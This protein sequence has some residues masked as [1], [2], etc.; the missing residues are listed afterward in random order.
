MGAMASEITSITIVYSTVY[1]G[2]AQRKH[3]SSAPL[4]FVNSPVSGEFPAQM[5]SNAKMFPFDDVI[6]FSNLCTWHDSTHYSC[7]GMCKVCSIHLTIFFD[8]SKIKYPSTFDYDGNIGNKLA[9][10]SRIW[11]TLPIKKQYNQFKALK[12]HVNNFEDIPNTSWNIFALGK[13]IPF[14]MFNVIISCSPKNL[15]SKSCAN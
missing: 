4:A 9:P 3:Q 12:K 11:I 14:T 2:A 7:H 8:E 13:H 10:E 5:A 15:S 6:I 1:S